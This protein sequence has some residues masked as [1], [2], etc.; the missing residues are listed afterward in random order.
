MT[1]TYKDKM[2]AM[3]ET[4]DDNKSAYGYPDSI[5]SDE[6]INRLEMFIESKRETLICLLFLELCVIFNK[7]CS[8]MN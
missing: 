2:T 8:T 7:N 6:L 3:K 5:K 1:E 4:I